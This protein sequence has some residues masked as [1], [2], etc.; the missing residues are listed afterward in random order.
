MNGRCWARAY[1]CR[2]KR[3]PPPSGSKVTNHNSKVITTVNYFT[4]AERI[5]YGTGLSLCHYSKIYYRRRKIAHLVGRHPPFFFNFAKA[6]VGLAVRKPVFGVCEQR[7]CRS[8][9]ASAQTDQR[10][11]LERGSNVLSTGIGFICLSSLSKLKVSLLFCS[12]YK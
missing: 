10:I 7:K 2:K 5:K 1:V 4:K 3:V 12:I 9:C 8:A 11:P 6:E